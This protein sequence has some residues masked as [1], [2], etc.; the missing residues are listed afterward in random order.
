MVMRHSFHLW[1]KVAAKRRPEFRLIV[2]NKS[3][4]NINWKTLSSML[5]PDWFFFIRVQKN[6]IRLL[7]AILWS[8]LILAREEEKSSINQQF[9]SNQGL[10]RE[11]GS[12]AQSEDQKFESFFFFFCPGYHLSPGRAPEWHAASHSSLLSYP[13]SNIHHNL[14]HCCHTQHTLIALNPQLHRSPLVHSAPFLPFLSYR[15]RIAYKLGA[16][17][18]ALVDWHNLASLARYTLIACC[19][20]TPAA[21][22]CY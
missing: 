11:K 19:T 12:S 22:S 10:T 16:S 1:H 15:K 14:F 9:S 5:D 20:P 7:T 21:Q 6:V 18:I 2:F 4:I 3:Y 13:A 8:G 17:L